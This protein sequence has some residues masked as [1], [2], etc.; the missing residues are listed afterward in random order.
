MRPTLSP[1]NSSIS[2]VNPAKGTLYRDF[3]MMGF[4]AKASSIALQ[5]ASGISYSYSDRVAPTVNP[6]IVKNA[7][8]PT[9]RIR[10]VRS[11]ALLRYPW[12]YSVPFARFRQ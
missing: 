6:L 9:V 3:S 11:L 12:R 4:S 7:L 8:W 10:T 1:K 5:S 2:Q